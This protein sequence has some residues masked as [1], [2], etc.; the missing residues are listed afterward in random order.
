MTSC[1]PHEPTLYFKSEKN[2]IRWELIKIENPR[3]AVD[4]QDYAFIYENGDVEIR[5]SFKD[6]SLKEATIKFIWNEGTEEKTL[7]FIATVETKE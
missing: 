6:D 7:E 2:V 3:I 1:A 4:E 5:G